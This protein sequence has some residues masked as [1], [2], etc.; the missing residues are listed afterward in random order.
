MTVSLPPVPSVSIQENEAVP[1]ALD[2]RVLFAPLSNDV[3]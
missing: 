1:V 2:V 3:E